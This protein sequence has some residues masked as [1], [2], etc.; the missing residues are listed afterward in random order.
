MIG[1]MYEARKKS[2]GAP[3]GNDNNKKVN[4]D[5]M[6]ESTSTRR[7]SRDG[8]AGQIGKEV[9]IDGRSVRRAEQFSRWGHISLRHDLNVLR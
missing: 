8:T 5:K 4:V 2:V 9:G 6:P 1:K 3:Q 7:E